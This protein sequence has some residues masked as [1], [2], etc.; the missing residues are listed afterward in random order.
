MEKQ[1]KDDP[2]CHSSPEGSLWDGG[3]IPRVSRQDY[4]CGC[5]YPSSLM[6]FNSIRLDCRF[7]GND[8]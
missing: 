6:R 2:L 8:K 5:D 3:G 7:H 4:S 1:L